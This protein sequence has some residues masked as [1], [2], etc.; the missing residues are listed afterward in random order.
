MNYVRSTGLPEIEITANGGEVVFYEI[1]ADEVVN[2]KGG[3]LYDLI[4]L[5]VLGTVGYGLP[6]GN[7][8]AVYIDG[9]ETDEHRRIA[10]WMAVGGLE[11]SVTVIF[12]INK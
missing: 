6:F 10:N 2:L 4:W 1:L 8:D 3:I 7:Y 5:R 12:R 9:F 11:L